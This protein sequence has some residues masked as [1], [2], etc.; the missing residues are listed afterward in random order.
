MGMARLLAAA[1]AGELDDLLVRHGVR[2]LTVFGSAGRGEPDPRDLDV[3]VAFER[4]VRGDALRLAE[5]LGDVA[6][7]DVDLGLADD[8][9]PL[10]R[11]R[12]LAAATPVWE[13]TPGAWIDA[14]VAAQ[15]ERMDTAWLRRADL[16]RRASP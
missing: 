11:E 2:V 13:S 6:G 12:A 1:A 4:G 7:T 8:A 15:L 9:T 10:F 5:E 3:G 14:A 16:E